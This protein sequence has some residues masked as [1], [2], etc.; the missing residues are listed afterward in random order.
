V[1]PARR[2]PGASDPRPSLRIGRRR[3]ED[4]GALTRMELHV[5]FLPV[6]MEDPR[7]RAVVIIDVLR[8]STSLVALLERGCQEV[9]IAPSVDAARR[10]RRSHPDV[11][12]AGEQGGRAPEGFDF[13]NSPAAF[14]RADLAGRRIVF[15]TTNGTRAMH[16]A[17]GAPVILVG[18]LRNRTAVAREG[19]RGAAERGVDITVLCA[20]REGRFSLD[21][22]Y[23]AG[24]VV[25]GILAEHGGHGILDLTDAALAARA[26]Y[27]GCPDPEA[28]YRMTRAGRN[29]LEIGLEEDLR[30]CAERDRSTIVPR[31]GDGVR[32]LAG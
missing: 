20:G 10:Y 2:T 22:A 23:T 11:L 8:A 29:V 21:D 28:L 7:T 6:E 32:L 3:R 30:Y 13:G 18:C 12:A 1:R 26:L 24:A 25:E 15:A 9:V 14:A 4:P 19:V 16:A 27:Q 17:A 31:V 5:A